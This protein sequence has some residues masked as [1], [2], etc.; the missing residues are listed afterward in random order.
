M[1]FLHP[2]AGTCTARGRLHGAYMTVQD[3]QLPVRPP[4]RAGRPGS[5]PA[6]T[7]RQRGLPARTRRVQRAAG[8]PGDA[9]PRVSG[10]PS[11]G[12]DQHAEQA[13][14]SPQ[15]AVQDQR[16]VRELHGIERQSSWRI[17]RVTAA[18]SGRRYPLGQRSGRGFRPG[19]GQPGTSFGVSVVSLRPARV[20]PGQLRARLRRRCHRGRREFTPCSSCCRVLRRLRPSPLLLRPSPSRIPL[21]AIS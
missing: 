16:L 4:S 12:T 18:R 10:A 6:V 2:G 15:G 13:L 9:G 20:H 21:R 11:G 1:G 7:R 17:T 14:Q 5:A 19:P 8:T 3:H